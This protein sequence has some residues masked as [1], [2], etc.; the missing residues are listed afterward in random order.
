MR[1]AIKHGNTADFNE[2]A[3][4]EEKAKFGNSRVREHY[5]ASIFELFGL[6]SSVII[7]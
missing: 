6:D 1:R 2:P 5:D 3:Q 4:I 7:S